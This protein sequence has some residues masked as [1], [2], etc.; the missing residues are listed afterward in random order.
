LSG[1]DYI[2]G[3]QCNWRQHNKLSGVKG[4]SVVLLEENKT[5]KISEIYTKNNALIL[6]PPYPF[7]L[8]LEELFFSCFH[9]FNVI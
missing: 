7:S 4:T 6:F 2:L 9:Y 8:L 1:V 3:K 5:P